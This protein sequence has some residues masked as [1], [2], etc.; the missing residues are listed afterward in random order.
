MT[1]LSDNLV[2]NTKLFANDISIFSVTG[3]KGLSKKNL[4]YD[5]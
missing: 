5:K 3:D 2:S 4:N 1:D